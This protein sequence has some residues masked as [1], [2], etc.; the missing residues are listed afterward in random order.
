M[1]MNRLQVLMIKEKENTEVK[2]RVRRQFWREKG[3]GGERGRR[4]RE[5]KI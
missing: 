1:R 2:E 5:R 4:K 3:K